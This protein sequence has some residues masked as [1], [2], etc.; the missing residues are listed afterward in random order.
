LLK[1]AIRDPNPVVF[2]ENELMYGVSF[3]VSDAV[4]KDDFVL[5]IG[6]AK[7]EIVGSDITLVAHSKAVGLCVEAAE[8][9]KSMGISAEVI[10]LRSIR[11]LDIDTIVASVKK[12]NHLVT[13]EGGWPQFGVGSEIVAQIMESEAFDHLDSPVYRITGADVPMPYAQKLEEASLPQANNVVDMVLKS[14]NKKK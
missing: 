5:P 3:D 12:T 1:A 8:Q 10:N 7:L 6:K 2:L 9:L 14:L 13:V 4:L 11:P